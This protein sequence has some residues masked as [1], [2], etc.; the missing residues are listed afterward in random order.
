MAGKGELKKW[1]DLYSYQFNAVKGK[2]YVS[3]P[4]GNHDF[5]RLAA[6]VRSSEDQLK[7]AMTFFYTMPGVPFMFY[8]DEI[9]L[10]H[11]FN[12]PPKEGS[13]GRSGS[14]I[15]MLWDSSVNA[16]YSTAPAD[17]L[18]LPIDQDPDRR[19]VENQ[20][21]N[22]GSLLNYVKDIIKLRR[23][24]KALCAE[25]DWKLVSSLDAPYPMIY[26]RFYGNEKWLVV[27]NPSNKKVTGEIPTYT[28]E[29][30]ISFGSY[31]SCKYKVGKD[32]DKISISPVSA[33]IY[34][35]H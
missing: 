29:P 22:P 28:N 11:D 19:T 18:Y 24:S 17:Q 15:P 27:I 2:G 14:R 6:G 20:E 21:L 34:K 4:S 8:G 16:G 33:V 25:G 5:N 13:G 1:Y 32:T 30:V 7:V 10:K 12:A 35:V 31:T 26:E 9:G 3:M 23:T